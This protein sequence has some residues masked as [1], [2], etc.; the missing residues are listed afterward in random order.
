MTSWPELVIEI[1][2]KPD[3]EVQEEIRWGLE[4][5]TAFFHLGRWKGRVSSIPPLIS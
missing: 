5:F 1:L 2:E 4:R 3:R